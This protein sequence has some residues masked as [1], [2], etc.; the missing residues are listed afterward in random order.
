MIFVLT[1]DPALGKIDKVLLSQQT[2]MELFSEGITNI[3]LTYRYEGSNEIDNWKGLVFSANGDIIQLLV[4]FLQLEGSI[5][6]Q[7]LPSTI[8]LVR[9]CGNRLSGTLDLE[10]LPDSLAELHLFTN[11]FVGSISLMKL[12]PEFQ[13]LNVNDNNL[14]GSLDLTQLPNTLQ[15]LYLSMNGFVGMTDFSKLPES[16]NVLSIQFT[17]LEGEIISNGKLNLKTF[18]CKVTI[19]DK[20][21]SA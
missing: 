7:W 1:I 9:M 3:Q 18:N 21:V 14:S 10:N 20:L 17:G 13:W 5:N 19:V 6:L 4:D 8:Q 16:L 11:R 2:L 15:C 12:P